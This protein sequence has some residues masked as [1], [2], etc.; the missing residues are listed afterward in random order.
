MATN[1][2]IT[3]H[4]NNA[5]HAQLYPQHYRGSDGRCGYFDEWR[6]HPKCENKINASVSTK[7]YTIGAL[8]RRIRI[9]DTTSEHDEFIA[10]CRNREMAEQI[11]ETLNRHTV[12]KG[13]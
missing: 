2:D 10:E 9:D 7:Y 4:P 5:T 12:V 13:V 3:R 1:S 11:A 6:C 8:L